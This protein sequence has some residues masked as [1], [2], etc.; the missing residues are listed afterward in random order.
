MAAL[1][2]S[3]LKNVKKLLVRVLSNNFSR[4]LGMRKCPNWSLYSDIF[5]D[6][7][8][9]WKFLTMMTYPIFLLLLNSLREE[10]EDLI[11]ENIPPGLIICEKAQKALLDIYDGVLLRK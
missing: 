11:D 7:Y 1:G 5:S 8:F 10:E 9:F 4:D 2:Y 3:Y 6:G